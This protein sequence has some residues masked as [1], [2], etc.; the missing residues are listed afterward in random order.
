MNQDKEESKLIE[1]NPYRQKEAVALFFE[2]AGFRAGKPDLE[3]LRRILSVFSRIPYENL[4]KIIKYGQFLEDIQRVRLPLEVMESYRSQQLGGTCFSL[5][6]L[7]QSILCIT[8]YECYP[9]MADMRRGRNVHCALVVLMQGRHFLVDPGYLLN[10]PML[11]CH[12][13]RNVF[14]TPFT[15]LEVSFDNEQS[16]FRVSTFNRGGK[17]WRYSFSELPVPPDVFLSRWLDSFR[18]N[19]MN[20]LCLNRLDK[21]GMVY[22]HNHYMRQTSFHCKESMNIQSRYHAVIESVFGIE[23]N[24]LEEALAALAVNRKRTMI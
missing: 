6:F 14:R 9:V 8:G 3:F 20:G 21:D 1:L 24:V 4:S 19:S 23:P 18:W 22:I 10:E 7:L 13:K 5:T 17:K 15:G 16:V 12:E 2:T 11:L